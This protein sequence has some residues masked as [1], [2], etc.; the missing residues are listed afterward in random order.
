MPTP[1]QTKQI[2]SSPGSG[3][4]AAMDSSVTA[5]NTLICVVS[6]YSTNSNGS[7]TVSDTVNGSWPTSDCSIISFTN[8]TA[9]LSKSGCSAGTPTVT[10]SSSGTGDQYITAFV[11]EVATSNSPAFDQQATNSAGSGTAWTSG[12]TPTTTQASEMV[13]YVGGCA[14]TPGIPA[15]PASG[16]TTL[17]ILQDN[18]TWQ[19]ISSG[20]KDV[21]STGAQSA[22][23]TLAASVQWAGAIATYKITASAPDK[24]TIFRQ[25]LTT[26]RPRPFAP[27]N[28]R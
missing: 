17:D 22:S 20:W 1:L 19:P 25:I 9:I 14:Q 6:W 16:Y 13:V 5:G 28:A 24:G 10:V 4:S 8:G 7:I 26:H 27:G 15:S 18:T 3:P 21:S 2:R 23:M 11:F 12:T